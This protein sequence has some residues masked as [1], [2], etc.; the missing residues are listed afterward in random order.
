MNYIE[1]MEKGWEHTSYSPTSF[2]VFNSEGEVIGCCAL[3]AMAL[4]LFPQA[5]ESDLYSK[6]GE[7]VGDMGCVVGIKVQMAS[8]RAG[9]KEA[10]IEA[11]RRI[12]E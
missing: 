12:L 10:A 9:S 11:V 1:A 4:G 5:K 2:F 8:D 3:G 6:V 7:I